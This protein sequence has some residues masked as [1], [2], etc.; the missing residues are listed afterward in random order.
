M[1]SIE[2]SS[3]DFRAEFYNAF[4][5]PNFSNPGT[6][7]SSSSFGQIT[8]MSIGPRLVQFALKYLF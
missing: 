2:G 5:D 3:L 7:A 4:S 8:S 6:N 1:P